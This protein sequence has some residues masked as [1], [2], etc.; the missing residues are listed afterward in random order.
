MIYRDLTAPADPSPIAEAI[1]WLDHVALG[2][3]ATCIAVIAIAAVGM[4]MLGGRLQVKRGVTAIIGCFILFGA[5]T[6]AA[7][8][9]GT[10]AFIA[11]PATVSATPI[12]QV[13]PPPMPVSPPPSM[14][15]PPAEDPYAG[16]SV[17]PR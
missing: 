2:T 10:L 3:L 9:Q 4:L 15:P 13:A 1:G 6:I 11:A 16:A 7:A 5:P 17:R 12:V 14:V 8:L